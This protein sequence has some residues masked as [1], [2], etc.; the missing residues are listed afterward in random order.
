M[1]RAILSL[2]VLAGIVATLS[3]SPASAHDYVR[4]RAGAHLWAPREGAVIQKDSPP[5]FGNVTF[6]FW[7]AWF[8]TSSRQQLTGYHRAIEQKLIIGSPGSSGRTFANTTLPS[9]AVLRL[10]DTIEPNPFSSNNKGIFGWTAGNS[11]CL[12]ANSAQMVGVRGHH[13]WGSSQWLPAVLDWRASTYMDHHDTAVADC[14]ATVAT[15]T[16]N[17]YSLRVDKSGWG[18]WLQKN[19]NSTH[20]WNT[21]GVSNHHFESSNLQ[22]AGD[23]GNNVSRVCANWTLPGAI[24]GFKSNCAVKFKRGSSPVPWSGIHQTMART[25]TESDNMTLEAMVKCGNTTGTCTAALQLVF[26][27]TFSGGF[28]V[29]RKTPTVTLQAGFWYSC[30][31]DSNHSFSTP[32]TPNYSSLTA[33]IWTTGNDYLMADAVLLSGYHT[34]ITQ[35]LGDNF[36]PKPTSGSTCTK[37]N[38]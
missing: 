18:L 24:A 11:G 31:L 3:P 36:Q 38:G 26:N 27:Y 9:C 6:D 21:K 4:T 34:S 16:F 13:D 37:V 19:D 22:W 29:S 15:C 25:S 8:D 10:D 28:Q 33:S 35:T 23:A 1:K 30:G 32:V 5:F 17:D 12:T 20:H 7:F 2:I 14:G